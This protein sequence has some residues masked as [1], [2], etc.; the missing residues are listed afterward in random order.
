MASA[1]LSD[2][3]TMPYCPELCEKLEHL[4]R[5]PPTCCCV[6]WFKYLCRGGPGAWRWSVNCETEEFANG[7]IRRPEEWRATETAV[8][9]CGSIDRF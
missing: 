7:S 1:I 3:S 4:V 5:L 6:C 8:R 9:L 2:K